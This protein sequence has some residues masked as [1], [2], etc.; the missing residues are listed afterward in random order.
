MFYQFLDSIYI[1]F[2]LW[3]KMKFAMLNKFKFVSFA[4]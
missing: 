2:S 3:H 1:L 4:K